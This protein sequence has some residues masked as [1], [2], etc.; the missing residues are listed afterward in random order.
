MKRKGFTLVELIAAIA[1]F[2]IMIAAISLG[3]TTST[4]TWKTGEAK[5]KTMYYAQGF[6]EAFKGGGKTKS[7]RKFD[8]ISSDSCYIYFNEDFKNYIATGA[9][10]KEYQS[11]EEWFNDNTSQTRIEG[12]VS[13]DTY[14]AVSS[15]NLQKRKYGGYVFAKIE[16][17][18]VVYLKVKL[19]DLAQGA[20]TESTREINIR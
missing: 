17:N 16:S 14:A 18:N 10:V 11:F 1:I 4:R 5:L 12:L 20:G 6:A 15:N 2:S 8:T 13:A 3:F 19:W 9:Y 7:D